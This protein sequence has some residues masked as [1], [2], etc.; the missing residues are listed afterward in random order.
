MDKRV[1]WIIHTKHQHTSC[2]KRSRM[3]HPG[4]TVHFLTRTRDV[5]CSKSLLQRLHMVFASCSRQITKYLEIDH[6]ILSHFPS[7][8]T[9]T[10]KFSEVNLKSVVRQPNN[11]TACI[12]D[13]TAL[14]YIQTATI[15]LISKKP[16]WEDMLKTLKSAKI[17]AE[18]YTSL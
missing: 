18:Y 7:L 4:I 6:N 1:P 2:V 13:K 14:N 12:T 10:V 15:R 17:H 11:Q 16:Y 5:T 9:H 8:I 3:E